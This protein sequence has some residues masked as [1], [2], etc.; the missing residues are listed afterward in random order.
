MKVVGYVIGGLFA[1]AVLIALAFVLELGGLKW[2]RFF[3]PKHENVRRE[4]FKATRSYNESKTQDL[5]RFM[6]QHKLADDAE[7]AAIESTIRVMFAD[8]DRNLLPNELA[9]FLHQVRGY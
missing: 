8:Y 1:L 3:A 2:E 6:H 4:V 7:R 9:D 5:A